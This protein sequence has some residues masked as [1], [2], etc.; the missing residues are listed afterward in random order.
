MNIRFGLFV[1]LCLGS[2]SSEVDMTVEDSGKTIVADT[3]AR[4]DHYLQWMADSA[5]FSG[6][7]LLALDGEIVI[8]KGYGLAND[9]LNLPVDPNTVFTIG[10]ITK[11]FTGAAILKLEEMGK[12]TVDDPIRNYFTDVPIDKQDITIH[13]L[14]TH[15]AGF[16]GAIG[17]DADPI[18]TADFLAE[19]MNTELLHGPGS[20]YEYSNVGYSLLGILVEQLS[21]QS[22]EGFLRKHFFEPAGMTQTGY[23][24]PDWSSEIL[25]QG[26]RRGQHW[27]TLHDRP[28]REDGPGW[29]LRAN[30]GILSTPMDMYRWHQILLEEEV[31]RET[32][33]NKYFAKHIEEGEGAGTYYGYGWAI[34]PTPRGTDLVTHNGGNGIF[35]ADMYRY[36][37]EDVFLFF[38]TNRA[39]RGL[40]VLPSNILRMVFQPEFQPSRGVEPD[41]QVF[42]GYPEG[43]LGAQLEEIVALLQRGREEDLKRLVTDFMAAPMQEM[44]PMDQHLDI[45]GQMAEQYGTLEL[46]STLASRQEL[47][48]IFADSDDNPITLL[49]AL[50]EEGKIVG[51]NG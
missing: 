19:A 26:Y 18:G 12:L 50:N 35:F 8:R 27:G 37:E 16:P 17:D 22:Y 4:I 48:L 15:S 41:G 51:I 47:E 23:V 6:S 9:S 46:R 3:T 40:E 44:G 7:V 11:Q 20:A 31:L 39:T 42:E 30:G 33:K 5:G 43:P 29:H 36:L 25:A 45:L 10:S 38:A 34:F 13:Q 32:S 1:V 24:L 2:C 21:G 49:I 14:L 28:W